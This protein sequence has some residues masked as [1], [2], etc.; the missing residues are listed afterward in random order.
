[1]SLRKTQTV[2]RE[3][4]YAPPTAPLEY[5]HQDDDLLIVNKPAGLLSV[6]G[7]HAPDCLETRI[8]V[9]F[10]NALT[11]H[12]LDMATSGVMVFALNKNAQRHV[13]LQFEKRQL[14]KVYI[15]CVSGRVS[16]DAGAIDLPLICDWPNRPRQKV[17]FENGKPA[18]TEWSVTER[19][20]D[21]TRVKLAPK[22]GR[23]HQL[24][25]HMLSLGHP[26]IGDRIYANDIDFGR[27]DRLLLHAETLR[28]RHPIG[29]A[30]HEFLS[31]C[32]F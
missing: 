9:D 5:I 30:W 27:A 16:D 15:A 21:M 6:P 20:D 12:R 22:T 29:G 23:S 4:I 8:K 28:L 3:F 10:P 26:I 31:P 32:P 25:V 19:K 1:M 2:L 18:Q 13:G 14:E 24:R 11:I 7:K 17:C